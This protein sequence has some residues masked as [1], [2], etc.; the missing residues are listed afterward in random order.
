MS[1]LKG[2]PEEGQPQRMPAPTQ[3]EVGTA[4]LPDGKSVV[5]IELRTPVGETT[6]FMEPEFAE[7]FAEAIRHQAA[8]ARNKLV[9]AGPGHLR[10]IENGNREQR[11]HPEQS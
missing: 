11:R 7:G 3:Y 2:V 4:Q 1:V 8:D 6:L 5:V 9:I 10:A